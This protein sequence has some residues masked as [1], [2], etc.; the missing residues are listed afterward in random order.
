MNQVNILLS[1]RFYLLIFLLY[2][3]NKHTYAKYVLT[4][5]Q[6]AL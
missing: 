4:E 1:C 2:L 5:K 6:Y 3:E